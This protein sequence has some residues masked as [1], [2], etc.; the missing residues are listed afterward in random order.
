MKGEAASKYLWRPPLVQGAHLDQGCFQRARL[1]LTTGM[2][3]L[4]KTN[5]PRGA[6]AARPYRHKTTAMFYTAAMGS[7]RAQGDGGDA[8]SGLLSPACSLA[9]A[10]DQLSLRAE[11]TWRCLLRGRMACS[12]LRSRPAPL[13]RG[14]LR[15]CLPDRSKKIGPAADR[16]QPC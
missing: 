11:P 13:D 1:R 12:S 9:L 4:R 3:T 16:P 15:G 14:P 10:V 7:R 6:G 8:G 2:R 5:L